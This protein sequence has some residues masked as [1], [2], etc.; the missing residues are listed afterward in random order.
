MQFDHFGE[1]ILRHKDRGLIVDSNLL[2][3]YLVG[4]A[5]L[6]ILRSFKRTK[7]Y[8]EN[9]WMILFQIVQ[10]FHRLIAMPS[11]LT[12]V[13]G[14]AN[15][16]SGGWRSAFFTVFRDSFETMEERHVPCRVIGLHPKF[17][18]LG[19]TD[20]SIL[21][22]AREGFLVLTVDFQLYNSLLELE[23][24]CINFHHLRAYV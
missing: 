22:I 4:R 21:E 20:S 18:L 12:E 24:G 9:D 7:D 17:Q 14:L 10:C 15:S 3:V 5:D 1:L 11:I 23:L 13:N 19:L 16:L 2:L 8:S 6:R